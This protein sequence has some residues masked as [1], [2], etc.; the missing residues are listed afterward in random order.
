M[1]NPA[2]SPYDR[3]SLFLRQLKELLGSYWSTLRGHYAVGWHRWWS[4]QV[5]GGRPAYHHVVQQFCHA[6]AATDAFCH[7]ASLLHQLDVS[8]PHHYH[9]HRPLTPHVT[10]VTRCAIIY[11]TTSNQSIS[12]TIILN[13]FAHAILRSLCYL[14]LTNV[15]KKSFYILAQ[16]H[17]C[18]SSLYP[19]WS[20]KLDHYLKFVTP[21]Y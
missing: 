2:Q 4:R 8:A 9:L 5:R 21:V 15:L 11:W 1:P 6:V 3:Q 12:T 17:G 10:I 14:K 18:H 19:E 20:K 13:C 16:M 7:R